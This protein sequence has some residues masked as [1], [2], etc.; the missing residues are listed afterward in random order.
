[1]C[2]LVYILQLLFSKHFDI[3]IKPEVDIKSKEEKKREEKL[4]KHLLIMQ[5]KILSKT[6]GITQ[7]IPENRGLLKNKIITLF[8]ENLS[9]F[10]LTDNL[11]QKHLELITEED[12]K[13]IL[14]EIYQKYHSF[15]GL[16]KSPKE[17]WKK[18]C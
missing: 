8:N 3:L 18:V 16:E 9:L 4:R 10:S 5:Q 6:T 7:K 17:K 11:Y 15:G 13:P 12:L 1:L 2:I 14:T